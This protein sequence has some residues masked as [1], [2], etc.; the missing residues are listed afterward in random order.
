[1]ADHKELLTAHYILYNWLQ[2]IEDVEGAYPSIFKT[3]LQLLKLCNRMKA[4]NSI[5][6]L[7]QILTVARH[8][9]FKYIQC[10]DEIKSDTPVPQDSSE[11][12]EKVSEKVLQNSFKVTFRYGNCNLSKAIENQKEQ[13]AK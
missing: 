4:D 7:F 6:L 12:G 5:D 9:N 11:D 13:E 3:Q 1:L 2:K 8:N 10:L